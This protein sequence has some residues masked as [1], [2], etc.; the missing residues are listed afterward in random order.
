MTTHADNPHDRMKRGQ[1]T[2]H[3]ST[4]ATQLVKFNEMAAQ[5]QICKRTLAKLVSEKRIPAVRIGK[6]VR[7]IPAEVIA[8]LKSY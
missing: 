6:S 7:F 5:L 4:P 1:P 8:A 3:H 2:W